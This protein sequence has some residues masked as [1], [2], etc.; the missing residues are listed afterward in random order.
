MIAWF[1]QRLD[2]ANQH[3]LNKELKPAENIA[4]ELLKLVAN[5]YRVLVL[6]K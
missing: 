2:K 1:N 4:H 6:L 5:E 3:L